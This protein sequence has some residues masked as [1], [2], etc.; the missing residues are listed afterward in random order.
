MEFVLTGCGSSSNT[1]LADKLADE[2]G[3]SAITNSVACQSSAHNGVGCTWVT[4][5]GLGQGVGCQ[6]I[7]S[8]GEAIT[9]GACKN[10]A[11]TCAWL[12]PFCNDTI[13]AN[14]VTCCLSVTDEKTCQ[15]S[16]Q[17]GTG[18]QTSTQGA[19]I[20]NAQNSVPCSYYSSRLFTGCLPNQDIFNPCADT[21]LST[22]CQAA[23]TCTWAR[24]SPA[25]IVNA[26]LFCTRIGGNC[27]PLGVTTCLV[28]DPN[29][30]ANADGTCND[31][32]NAVCTPNKTPV[33]TACCAGTDTTCQVSSPG[34]SLAPPSCFTKPV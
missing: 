33:P 24:T 4:T 7:Q 23:T 10:E 13:T 3:C 20:S 14:S 29:C 12:A 6:A 25:C 2:S 34:C 11:G 16:A 18:C 30:I 8:C 17:A 31:R 19:S 28:S 22:V 26:P 15:V 21:N 9:E 1:V 27:C 32:A 5:P